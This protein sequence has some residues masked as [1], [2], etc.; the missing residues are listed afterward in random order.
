MLLIVRVQQY[1]AKII[2]GTTMTTRMVMIIVMMMVVMMMMR[3]RRRM[4][5]R[6]YV[7]YKIMP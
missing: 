7:V 5:N 3:R 4:V 2:W 6:T 1:N